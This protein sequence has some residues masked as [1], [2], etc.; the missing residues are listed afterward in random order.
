MLHVCWYF[1]L[2]V[3]H[4]SNISCLHALRLVSDTTP[5]L[6]YTVLVILFTNSAATSMII[7]INSHI[8]GTAA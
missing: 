5:F 6:L 1:K 2:S 3:G 7:E 8:N 4:I